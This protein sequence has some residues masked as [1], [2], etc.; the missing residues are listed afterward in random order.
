[1]LFM[2]VGVAKLLL[3]FEDVLDFA[4][5]FLWWISRLVLLSCCVED[6]VVQSQGAA[7]I[8]EVLE[9]FCCVSR[10]RSVLICSSWVLEGYILRGCREVKK[11][12]LLVSR[13]AMGSFLPFWL[14]HSHA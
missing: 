4:G 9:V 14:Q 8:C 10:A 12:S 6:S 3:W 2:V 1:M 11:G 7:L 5:V 13:V